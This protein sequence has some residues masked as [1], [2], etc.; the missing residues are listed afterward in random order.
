MMGR[1]NADYDDPDNFT[2]FLF[3]SKAGLWDFYSS[4]EL[5]RLM[6]E[7]RV[8]SEPVT[9][10]K[11]YHKIENH[12][13]ESA[14]LLP[15]FHDIDYR[16]AGPKVRGLK[17]HSSPPYVKYQ[18]LGK[19][20]VAAPGVQRKGGGGILYAPLVTKIASLDPSM[21]SLQAAQQRIALHL[22]K[23][24]VAL[25]VGALKPLKCFVCFAP[26]GVDLGNLECPVILVF[27]DVLH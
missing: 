5:D 3:H 15:L 6:E 26:V 16:V 18:E 21:I 11:F 13:L 23:A 8:Q 17:L 22:G 25:F 10:E 27:F 14:F 24:A 1:Y 7:A 12:M 2:Y 4:P 9:R 19:A 20:E